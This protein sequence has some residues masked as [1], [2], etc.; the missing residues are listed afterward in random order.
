M[1]RQPATMRRVISTVVIVSGLLTAG[2]QNW[3]KSSNLRNMSTLT[4]HEQTSVRQHP[5]GMTGADPNGS[6]ELPL[7]T[8]VPP[9]RDVRLQ[10][11][12]VI[13]VKFFYTPE[14]DVTQPIRPDGRIAVQLLGEVLA[15]GKTPGEL[16][17]NLL[18][19]YQAH[20]KDPK[21][22]I[23]LHSQYDRRVFVGGE[24]ARPG[25]IPMPADMTVAEAIMEA[26]GF[27]MQEAKVDS[28]VVMR[29][30][31]RRWQGYLL[32]MK[33]MLKGYGTEPFFLLPRD[34]VYV[35]QTRIVEINQWLEQHV[36]KLI[37]R[38]P[39]YFS[40]PINGR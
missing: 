39:F 21:I 1:I 6:S 29:Q 26:G 25:V 2:C 27:D 33:P 18:S 3:R 5:Q 11:G 24:V 36:S 28:V 14:L 4:P 19:R 31:G 17:E 32:D 20:L 23:L 38:V 12:D 8:D 13:E 10:P 7:E 40:Y 15:E 35:P 22:T 9:G 16:R 37:P 30:M 34:V